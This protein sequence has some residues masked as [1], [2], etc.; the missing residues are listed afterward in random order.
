MIWIQLGITTIKHMLSNAFP[1][2]FGDYADYSHGGMPN[3]VKLDLVVNPDEALHE[4]H[5]LPFKL[6]YRT[7]IEA[8]LSESDTTFNLVVD[9]PLIVQGSNKVIEQTRL[10]VELDSVSDKVV[11]NVQ[12]RYPAKKG[13]IDLNLDASGQ[14]NR[15]DGNLAWRMPME[16]YFHGNLNV[17]ALLDRGSNGGLK[18]DININPS[19]LVFNDTIWEV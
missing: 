8:N 1:Q 6:A 12:S 2:Y 5:K 11:L 7:V 13:M 15:I 14:N 18:A 9:A 10:L 17:D 4:M 3:E 19:Q 16:H